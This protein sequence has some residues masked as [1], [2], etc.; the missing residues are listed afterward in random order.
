[1]RYINLHIHDFKRSCNFKELLLSIKRVI[2][3]MI[4]SHQLVNVH[5]QIRH[6][7][8]TTLITMTECNR[9]CDG[10]FA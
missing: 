6:N 5:K 8:K 9:K 3:V 10:V 2:N 4:C 1:M 7:N